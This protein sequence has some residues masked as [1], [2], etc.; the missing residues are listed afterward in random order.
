MMKLAAILIPTIAI[1]ATFG[2]G[3]PALVMSGSNGIDGTRIDG[4][5]SCGA[6]DKPGH[7]KG[8]MTIKDGPPNWKI[9]GKWDFDVMVNTT[10]DASAKATAVADGL[11]TLV[12]ANSDTRE[13]VTVGTS[14]GVVTVSG[15][16]G[17]SV[18][19]VDWDGIQDGTKQDLKA[20]DDRLTGSTPQGPRL[21]GIEFYWTGVPVGARLNGGAATTTVGVGSRVATVPV[22]PCDSIADVTARLHA[23]FLA[24]GIRT[25]ISRSGTALMI[26]YERDENDV[27]ES[28]CFDAGIDI[29]W[30]EF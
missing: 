3:V 21:K 20:Q 24:R 2:A 17:S 26:S 7:V 23:Q 28:A 12:N 18:G 14:G 5:L 4:T 9:L 29:G 11:R 6:N 27:V 19:V 22:L 15:N 30:S 1:G 13:V 10:G 8:T 25:I 16:S